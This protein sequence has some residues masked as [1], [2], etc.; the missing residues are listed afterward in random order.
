M[1]VYGRLC[2]SQFRVQGRVSMQEIFSI[3]SNYS[4][5]GGAWEG[6]GLKGGLHLWAII[7]DNDINQALSGV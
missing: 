2:I 7:G 6:R 4:E 5:Y 1:T 3:N